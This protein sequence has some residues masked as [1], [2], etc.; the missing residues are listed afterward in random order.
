[1]TRPFVLGLTGSIGMGKTT[2]AGMFAD[3]GV[4]VW[5]ADAAVHALYAADGAAVPIVAAL[6][7]D[8]VGPDGVDRAALKSWVARTPDGLARLE[9]G[10]H[11]LVAADRAAFVARA[12]AQA[13]PVVVLDVPLLFETGAD[14]ACD[15]VAVVSA[16]EAV[17]RARVLARPGMT[18]QTFAALMARQMPDAEKRA[19]AD[20]VIATTDL[21]SARGDVQRLL[22]RIRGNRHA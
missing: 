14:R 10:V 18:P 7:P 3:A 4:P 13:Q 20:H 12:A 15:A 9:G 6:C 16:P 22:D 8:A 19:R 11:P 17:Q 1:M 21:D 5:D 2:T